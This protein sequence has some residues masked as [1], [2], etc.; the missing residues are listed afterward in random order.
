MVVLLLDLASVLLQQPWAGLG[1]ETE[2]VP[3]RS[4]VGPMRLLQ[5]Y[6]CALVFRFRYKAVARASQ[7]PV[8]PL[9][10]PLGG[11]VEHLIWVLPRSW[12]Q[13]ARTLLPV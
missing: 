1:S 9:L 8:A 7:S 12:K 5:N 2:L 4:A 6:A 13:V 10:D 11:K 3:F